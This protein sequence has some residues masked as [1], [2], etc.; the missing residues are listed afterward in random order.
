MISGEKYVLLL[1]VLFLHQLL[2]AQHKN[3]DEIKTDTIFSCDQKI[4]SIISTDSK[5][6]FNGI[7]KYYHKN[8]K[9]SISKEYL[10]GELNGK[11]VY[12]NENGDSLFT[13]TW[14]D[15]VLNGPTI[16][17]QAGNHRLFVENYYAG[18]LKANTIYLDST[19]KPFEGH[20]NKFYYV[21]SK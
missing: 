14:T 10:H 5:S 12:F 17:Y 1:A 3:V 4:E 2:P 21:G 6:L 19:E 7:V 13:S 16:A 8:G 11:V 18:K 9:V 15:N 20:F